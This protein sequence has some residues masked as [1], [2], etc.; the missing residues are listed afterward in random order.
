MRGGSLRSWLR[1]RTGALHDRLDHAMSRL[2]LS[3]R[4]GLGDFLLSH[5]YGLGAVQKGAQA[6]A[7]RHLSLGMANYLSLVQADLR[8]LGIRP[9]IMEPAIGRDTGHDDAGPDDTDHDRIGAG[10]CYVLLGSRLGMGVLRQ[11]GYWRGAAFAHSA[12][13]EDRSEGRAW[14]DLLDWMDGGGNAGDEG[15]DAVLIGAQR[16]FAAFERGLARALAERH[17]GLAVP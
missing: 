13:M 17:H 8:A 11:R 5:A 14:T 16:A 6:F 1:D 2:D 3:T 15:R 12:Y 9:D 4:D 10:G 7:A